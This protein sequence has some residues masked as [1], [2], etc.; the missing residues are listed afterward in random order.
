MVSLFSDALWIGNSTFEPCSSVWCYSEV[1][2]QPLTLSEAVTYKV[3]LS[4]TQQYNSLLLDRVIAL[5]VLFLNA[6]NLIGQD[7]NSQ[8]QA[9]CDVIH[10]DMKYV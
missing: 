8:F 4:T 2:E 6:S 7:E 9:T 10:N 3:S 1:S 5:P